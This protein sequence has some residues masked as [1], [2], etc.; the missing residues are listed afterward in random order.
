MRFRLALLLLAAMMI[1]LAVS[2]C[3]SG[4]PT[5]QE[6]LFWDLPQPVQNTVGQRFP[7]AH[8]ETVERLTWKDGVTWYRISFTYR[9]A[10]RTIL[11]TPEGETPETK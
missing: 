5:T 7:R 1:N 4:K 9:G 3:S 8:M 11:L 6:I 10:S 2:G